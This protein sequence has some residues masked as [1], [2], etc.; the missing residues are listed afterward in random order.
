[1]LSQSELQKLTER[2]IKQHVLFG[3]P[4]QGTQLA[5]KFYWDKENPKEQ[6]SVTTTDK[7]VAEKALSYIQQH[8]QTSLDLLHELAEVPPYQDVQSKSAEPAE[9]ATLDFSTPDVDAQSMYPQIVLNDSNTTET[10]QVVESKVQDTETKTVS[11]VQ[12]EPETRTLVLSQQEYA[13]LN[14]LT[15]GTIDAGGGNLTQ[16]FIA[17]YLHMTVDEFNDIATEINAKLNAK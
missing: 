14:E 5:I 8:D 3:L 11:A 13:V 6:D 12:V 4:Y 15:S 1:M 10:Q 16:G 2:A 9:H 7:Y 17:E